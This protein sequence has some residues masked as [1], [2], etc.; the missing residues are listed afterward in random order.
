VRS[1]DT[2]AVPRSSRWLIGVAA[3]LAPPSLRKSWK[4]EWLG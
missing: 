4:R 3:L 2:Y 1:E